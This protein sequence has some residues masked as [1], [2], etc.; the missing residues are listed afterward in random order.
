MVFCFLL[1]IAPSGCSFCLF[2][3]SSHFL[4]FTYLLTPFLRMYR[5]KSKFIVT[6]YRVPPDSA[7]DCCSYSLS[8]QPGHSHPRFSPVIAHHPSL[9][10]GH[11]AYIVLS[12]LYCCIL[13]SEDIPTL[14]HVTASYSPLEQLNHYLLRKA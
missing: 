14:L 12:F 10:M 4:L 2:L 13:C 3:S 8:L 7:L 9:R 6:K 5:I 1:K 11:D